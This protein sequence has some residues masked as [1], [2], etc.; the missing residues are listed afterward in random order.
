LLLKDL[1]KQK[2]EH[3]RRSDYILIVLAASPE[4][5][6]TRDHGKSMRRTSQR[7]GSRRSY[8]PARLTAT[9]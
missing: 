9:L 3:K 8:L 4:E 6:I 7:C 5:F 2:K 1:L